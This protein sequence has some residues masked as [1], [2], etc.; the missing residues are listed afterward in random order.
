MTVTAVVD[1]ES[2]GIDAG[3]L[4]ELRARVRREIDSGLLRSCQ[5]ALAKDG[6][7]AAFDTL[8]DAGPDTR[9]V[10]FSATK[11][12]VAA[13]AWL[14][15]GENRLD[16]ERRVAEYI[17]EFATNGKDVVTVEQVMLHT[18]G[19]PRAPLGPPAWADRDRR[20]EAFARW[21]LNW[22]PG[23]AYEY[24]P[25]SAHWVLAELIERVSGRDYRDVVDERVTAALGLPRVLGIAPDGQDGIAELELAGEPASRDELLEIFGVPELPVTEVT[26]EA[27]LSFNEA[28]VR[29]VGVPGGGGIATA[30]TVALFYQA[31]LHDPDRLWD[32]DVLADA[33]GRVRNN[34]PDPLL[35]VTAN[36]ALGVVV[37][38]D[39]GNAN[40]RGF[41]HT[42]SPRTFGHNG[43]GGQIAWADPDSGLSFCYVTNG[44]DV[45]P[46]REGRRG[47][48]LSSRAA[49]C[50][51]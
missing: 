38:G 33:T 4:D 49:V 24:H 13:A 48:G 22:E 45:N 12:F 43:A 2:L 50:A 32:A 42:Q 44:R 47:I 35:G 25:T 8:G 51:T 27:L 19:F 29:A 15:I 5:Y 39:D 11:A 16:I 1:P 36:R 30:A 40:R 28:D 9:Y 18:S 17:P 14:L 7:L 23:T 37:A 31:L 10:I 41:G 34:L 21:R 46:I 26:D 3:R 20:L 6:Q